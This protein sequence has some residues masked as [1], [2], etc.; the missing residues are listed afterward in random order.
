MSDII[1]AELQAK[2]QKLMYALTKAAARLSFNKFLAL[3]EI[4]E[5]EYEKIKKIWKEKLDVTPYV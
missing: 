3:L 1:D 5:D 4:S 2:M